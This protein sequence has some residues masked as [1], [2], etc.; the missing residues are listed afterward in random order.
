MQV[1]IAP[2]FLKGVSP[3]I[4]RIASLVMLKNE[5][6]RIAVT[7]NS[8]LRYIDIFII[9]DTGSVDNTIDIVQDLCQKHTKEFHLKLG[10]FVDFAVSRNAALDFA[11]TVPNWDYL[12][13]V[14]ANDELSAATLLRTAWGRRQR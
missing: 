7:I 11:Q 5:S 13:L 6:E 12:L 10:N 3:F 4:M 8:L 2:G 1:R 9:F 14:D